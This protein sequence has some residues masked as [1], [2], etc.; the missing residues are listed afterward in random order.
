[1][2]NYDVNIRTHEEAVQ[3][4]KWMD[5]ANDVKIAQLPDD[6]RID[7]KQDWSFQAMQLFRNCKWYKSERVIFYHSN[8]LLVLFTFTITTTIF[9]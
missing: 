8:V 1:M 5:G 7:E 3:V 6:G 9:P 4:F 2:Q